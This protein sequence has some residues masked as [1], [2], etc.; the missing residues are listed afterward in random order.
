MTSNTVALPVGLISTQQHDMVNGI[1][2]VYCV[3]AGL[4]AQ[5]LPEYVD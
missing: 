2:E 5:L 1:S 3:I 4:I